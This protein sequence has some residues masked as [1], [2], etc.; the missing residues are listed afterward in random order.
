VPP[1]AL[2]R[3]VLGVHYPTDVVAGSVLGAAVA[4]G[5]RRLANRSTAQ[6]P[7]KGNR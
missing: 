5:A 1:M 2:S 6:R 4:V 7:R 3:M